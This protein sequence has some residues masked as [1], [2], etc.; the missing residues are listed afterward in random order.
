MMNG[1]SMASPQ[2]TGAAALLISAGKAT[3]G[4]FWHPSRSGMA[5][6]STARF[7]PGYTANEQGNGLIDVGK[8]WSLLR[9]NLEPVNITSRVEVHTLLSDFL[10]DPG[11]GPG[12]YD[13]EGVTAGQSYTRTYTFT[14]NLGPEPARALPPPL[15]RQRRHLQHAEQRELDRA[16][17]RTST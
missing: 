8:A 16:C 10:A 3:D 14:R 6:N 17:R 13:R 12:I 15:G 1:T 11:L 2:A 7:I 4:M 9:N 5:M